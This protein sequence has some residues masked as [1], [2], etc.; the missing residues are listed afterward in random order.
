VYMLVFLAC[1][2]TIL[3]RSMAI[4]KTHVVTDG[5][6]KIL[7]SKFPEAVVMEHVKIWL[8]GVYCDTLGREQQQ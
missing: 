2:M 8:R 3:P 7:K 5:Y 6:D 4:V 1:C